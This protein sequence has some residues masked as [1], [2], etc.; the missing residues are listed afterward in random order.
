MEIKNGG[1]HIK[2]SRTKPL[3]LKKTKYSSLVDGGAVGDSIP[4]MISSSKVGSAVDFVNDN[5]ESVG[6]ESS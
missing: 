1:G 5:S 6:M 4:Y 2:S 3:G